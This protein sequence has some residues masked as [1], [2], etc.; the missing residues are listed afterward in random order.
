[1][2][3]TSGVDPASIGPVTSAYVRAR[4]AEP[5]S[6]YGDCIAVSAPVDPEL[7]DLLSRLVCDGIIA[8]G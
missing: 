3:D 8:P 4:D 6:S 7:A 2:A 5:K 1:M